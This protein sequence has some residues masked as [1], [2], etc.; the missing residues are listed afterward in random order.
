M[1]PIDSRVCKKTRESKIFGVPFDPANSPERL[2][3]KRAYITHVMNAHQPSQVFLDPYDIIRA[4]LREPPLFSS[5]TIWFGKM[6]VDSWLMPRPNLNDLS[7][8]TLFHADSFLGSNGCWKYALKVA[9]FVEENVF[10]HRPVMIGIDHSLTGGLLLAL[11]KKYSNLNVVVLDAHFDVMKCN[12]LIPSLNHH[13]PDEDPLF[14]HCG[15]FLSFVLERNIIQPQNLWVLGV[16]EE[17]LAKSEDGHETKS[18]FNNEEEMRKWIDKGVHLFSKQMVSSQSIRIDLSGPTYVSIDM[19][20]GSLSSVFSARFMN[21]YGLTL[22]AFLDLLACVRRSIENAKVPLVGL[23][24]M[25]V[26]IHFHEAVEAMPFR[27]YT[28]YIIRNA[29]KVFLQD[30]LKS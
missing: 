23:D 22:R 20:V 13:K 8:L 17:V 21:C 7:S 29:L 28:R 2:N 25:E 4:D 19:D 18:L 3:L 6:P 1:T 5:E 14:C 9:Q 16:A 24:I 12:R 15:N 26:D 10:P 30:E 11:S 27:D